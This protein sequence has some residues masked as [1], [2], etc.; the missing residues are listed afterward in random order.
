MHFSKHNIFSK[1]KASENYFIVNLLSENADILSHEE[2]EK[3]EALQKGLPVND[4]GFI[5]E[6]ESKGYMTDNAE[7]DKL[8]NRKYLD[9]LDARDAD[10]IQIF[11]VPNYSCNFSCSYC[12]QDEYTSQNASTENRN[13]EEVVDAFFNYIK[14]EFTNRKKYVTLFGGEPLINSLRQKSLIEY[15]LR[16]ANENSLPVCIVTNGYT[17]IDYIPVL[18]S[19]P[20]REVQITLDGTETVH[21]TRRHLKNGSETF[22]KIVKG[23]DECLKNHLNVNLRIVVDKENIENLPELAAFAIQKGWTKRQNF[24]TQIGRNYEL[25]H[26]Q[27][28]PEKLFDRISLYKN[29]YELIRK[30]PQILEFHKP[31]YSISKFLSENGSL[32]D[33]LFDSCPACKT[34]WAFD[35][36]GK[37]Y[38]CTATVGKTD[39]SLGT[40]FPTIA[41]NKEVINRWEIRDVLA[42]AECKTCNLQ[43]ACGGGCGAVAKNSTGNICS[44]NCRPVKELLEL[45]FQS[46]FGI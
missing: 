19:Y 10:E 7:E 30:F 17:L 6:L 14:S 25:H 42:I 24:K 9:F 1:F 36:T 13:T 38:P 2:G 18:I 20:I 33:P 12:Y 4:T 28:A 44:P 31:A 43:L 22:E 46:Y 26:C 45:G 35:H 27:A 39:E 37:I 8:Y 32:P 15:F 16:R 21:N 41:I 5:L 40:F 34:E 29:I 23:I 3:L 11:F